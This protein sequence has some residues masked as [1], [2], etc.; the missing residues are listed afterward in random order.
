M[1][2]IDSKCNTWLSRWNSVSS[3]SSSSIFYTIESVY[4]TDIRSLFPLLSLSL[5]HS[6]SLHIY[7]TIMCKIDWQ[8]ICVTFCSQL[9]N[10]NEHRMF[11]CCCSFLYS[12]YPV[13]N[14]YILQLEG[15]WLGKTTHVHNTHPYG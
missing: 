13:C 14:R 10:V 9:Q 3:D 12:H 1:H 5:S 4:H 8:L 15:K 2:D 11:W 6:L 7:Y